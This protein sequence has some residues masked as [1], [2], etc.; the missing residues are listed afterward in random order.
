MVIFVCLYVEEGFVRAES[1]LMGDLS[2]D[3]LNC[4][5][6]GEMGGG[7]GSPFQV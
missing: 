7:G 2:G 1:W 6:G 5:G 3:T 4:G